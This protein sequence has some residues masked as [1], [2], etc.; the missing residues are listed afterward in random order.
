MGELRLMLLDTCAI[1]WLVFDEKK[2]SSGVLQ[3]IDQ[4][5]KILICS[6]SFW[7]IGIKIK[8]KKLEI[9]LPLGNVV[10]HFTENDQT[11][12]IAPD[13][14]IVLRALQLDWNHRD[15]VDRFI[16]ATAF[17]FNAEI[18]TADTTI[19]RFYQKTTS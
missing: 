15:P 7:E 18:I 17:K 9:P 12:I 10:Q 6:L 3:R 1:I 11:E 2:L 16:V 19:S 14:G 5:E 4:G 13:A 8:K